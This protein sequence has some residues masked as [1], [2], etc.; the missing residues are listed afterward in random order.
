MTMQAEPIMLELITCRFDLV[1]TEQD[2]P[3]K[4]V[5]FWQ[6]KKCNA[7]RQITYDVTPCATCNA[8]GGTISGEM[9]G[10]GYMTGYV[11]FFEP[12]DDCLSNG[13]CPGCSNNTLIAGVYEAAMDNIDTFICPLCGWYFDHSRFNIDE[14]DYDD[15]SSS[16]DYKLDGY[17]DDNGANPFGD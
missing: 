17:G 3:D 10:D 4:I 9:Q 15:G 16:Y 12:C 13:C 11:E 5:T 6:C 2:Q 14:P 8:R 7:E 1:A